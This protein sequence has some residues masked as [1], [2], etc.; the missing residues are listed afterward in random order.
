MESA[1]DET[2]ED[3]PARS[4]QAAGPLC[5]QDFIEQLAQAIV[6]KNL[7]TPAVFLLELHKPV[8][9]LGSML[10]LGVMPFLAP[11]FGFSYI[12]R[13]ALVLEDRSEVE[14]LIARIEEL[15]H[16]ADSRINQ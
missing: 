15:A 2:P 12:E 7:A 3:V 4:A 11:F 6:R 5:G 13:L 16:K 10:V 14:R 8:A 9:P 1:R